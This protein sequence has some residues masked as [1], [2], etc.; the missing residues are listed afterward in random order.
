MSFLPYPLETFLILADDFFT[1]FHGAS[2]SKND[3]LF[4]TP[5][6]GTLHPDGHERQNLNR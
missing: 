2:K 1:P 5:A 3:V 6:T 4:A